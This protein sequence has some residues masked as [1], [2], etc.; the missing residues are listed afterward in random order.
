MIAEKESDRD[1][2]AVIKDGIVVV[3]D[4][5][6]LSFGELSSGLSL[7]RV[8]D[9]AEVDGLVAAEYPSWHGVLI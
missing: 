7:R 8:L 6:S 3:D 4:K 5:V 9:C 2:D 1:G